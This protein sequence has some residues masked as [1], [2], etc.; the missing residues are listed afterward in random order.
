VS[1]QANPE[2]ERGAHWRGE[3]LVPDLPARPADEFDDAA[4]SPWQSALLCAALFAVDPVGLGG[5]SVHA[6]AGPVRERWQ[7][8]LESLWPADAPRRRAPANIADD[9]LI[10]GLDIA[11]TLRSGR[12]VADRGLL[13]EADGGFVLL[14]MAER[15]PPGTAA[16]IA[17]AMDVG[18]VTLQRDGLATSLPARFGVV[19]LDERIGEDE[20]P[21][22][23]LTDRLAFAVDLDGVSWGEAAQTPAAP[24]C[25]RITAAREQLGRIAL[26]D[27][28]VKRLCAVSLELGIGSAR[29][30]FFATRA[31][32]A[33]AALEG[34]DEVREADAILAT[35]LVLAHRARQMPA[36]PEE[37]DA[38]PPS[39][40]PEPPD[41]PENAED[42]QT[43]AALPEDI[44]LAAAR[45]AIP[46]GL[47]DKLAAPNMRGAQAQAGHAGA[48]ANAAQRGRPVGVR[49]QPPRSGARLNVI[50]TLRAAAPWQPLR[51]RQSPAPP[52]ARGRVII[53]PEDFRV[54][55]FKQR[56]ETVTIFI[57]DA[58]GS[59]ALARLAEAKGAV[60]LLLA[61]CYVRRDQVALIGFRG[62]SAEL[63]LP[64]TRSLT[65]AKRSLA[66]LPGGGGTPLASG[67]SEGLKLAQ[68]ARRK[69]QTPV[70]VV[71]T[72]GRANVGIDGTGGRQRAGEDALGVARMIRSDGAMSIVIDTSPRAQMPAQHLAGALNARYVP[73]PFANAASLSQAVRAVQT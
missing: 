40:T 28:I 16:R 35:R 31:A 73:L 22:G 37:A 14:A 60:E 56:S 43:E 42:E 5:I 67:L 36:P 46:Q 13:A 49:A 55:R 44:M 71:L 57:V 33:L 41:S 51:R 4:R 69:G 54:T 24:D 45:A 61:D 63:L 11:A 10:G 29:A 9:R 47:L 70:L 12:P 17:A 68:A 64:P 27:E 1:G 32:R 3:M 25:A 66:G 58:S 65:R 8:Y 20:A 50:E 7:T 34:R 39:E 48:L 52:P 21:P 6:H 72:D 15:L 19:A 59:T 18:R 53:R 23:A 30:A 26:G 2:P 62:R 38:P